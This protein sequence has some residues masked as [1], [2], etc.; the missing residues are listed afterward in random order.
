MLK[1]TSS[2]SRAIRKNAFKRVASAST[3]DE[4]EE[5]PTERRMSTLASLLDSTVA[6]ANSTLVPTPEIS[7]TSGSPTTANTDESIDA[8]GGQTF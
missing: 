8:S 7:V 2:Y 1:R 6:I 5:G 3:S 4:V